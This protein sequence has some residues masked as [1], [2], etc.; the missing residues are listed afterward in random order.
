MKR[1]RQTNCHT[2]KLIHFLGMY[3]LSKK[4]NALL[5]H[6]AHF[7]LQPVAYKRVLV[8]PGSFRHQKV[9]R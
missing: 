6:V 5:Q 1:K 3:C 9:F 8:H 4:K 2:G 7:S